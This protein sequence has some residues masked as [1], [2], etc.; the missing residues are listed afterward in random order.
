S[1]HTYRGYTNENKV[2]AM[3]GALSDSH[4]VP[5]ASMWNGDVGRT[6]A[7]HVDPA[8]SF[9]TYSY[10]TDYRAPFAQALLNLFVDTSDRGVD[11]YPDRTL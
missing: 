7:W 11:N 6:L 2:I 3:A 4:H 8:E 10:G 5:L 1:P 9:L